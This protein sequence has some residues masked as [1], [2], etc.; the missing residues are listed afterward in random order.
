MGEVVSNISVWERNMRCGMLQRIECD[1]LYDNV[2]CYGDARESLF[3]S[4]CPSVS[5]II[6]GPPTPRAWAHE[7][8]LTA[9]AYGLLLRPEAW[10][11]TES[12]LQILQQTQLLPSSESSS[13]A[14]SIPLYVSTVLRAYTRTLIYGVLTIA[15][16][17]E[18][19]SLFGLCLSPSVWNTRQA[20]YL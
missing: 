1:V 15:H 10:R 9:D 6:T 8:F 14:R 16:G 3:S 17:R 18:N 2:V 11:T 12:P 13:S 7:S 20:V 4:S 5:L 19:L